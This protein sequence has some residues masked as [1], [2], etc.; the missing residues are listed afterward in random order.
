MKSIFRYVLL[1]VF[2][3]FI[4]LFL[5]EL[6][7]RFQIID[8]YKSEFQAL[9]PK[10]DKNFH[11]KKVMIF[12][13]SFSAF[14]DGYVQQ[15]RRRYPKI[16]FINCSVSGIG[17]RQHQLFFKNRIKTYQPD[18]V[19]YQFYV[20]NDLLDVKQDYNFSTSTFVKS[21]YYYFSDQ[22][23]SLKYLNYK[24]SVFK[25]KPTKFQPSNVFSNSK[26]YNPRVVNQIKI[27]PDYLS[28]TINVYGQ[29]ES[30]MHDWL[31][32]F[33]KLKSSCK[34]PIKL[35]VLPHPAQVDF[36]LMYKLNSFGTQLD[37]GVFEKNYN[38]LYILKQKSGVEVLDP[39]PYFQDHVDD[40]YYANDPHLNEFGQSV[41]AE[42]IEYN[43][44]LDGN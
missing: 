14:P 6:S 36:D 26:T 41:L 39:L 23:L 11:G 8:F 4:T 17:I 21:L 37:E 22:F 27:N 5:F 9:N 12:G 10:V 28:E 33:Q 18:L 13:D 31:N 35:L 3:S 25:A 43:M 34:V 38:L 2:I 44:H 15:L 29:Q 19:I 20:G 7:Y 40:L 30:K 24:L 16:Q 42:F 1:F 32:I